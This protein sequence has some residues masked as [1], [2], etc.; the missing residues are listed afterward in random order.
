MITILITYCY[1]LPF[2]CGQNWKEYYIQNLTVVILSTLQNILLIMCFI[3]YLLQGSYA[4]E[5]TQHKL[6]L[7]EQTM[8]DNIENRFKE[9]Q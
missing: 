1:G 8:Y 4:F 5:I 3:V 6:H 2:N 9:I 7:L